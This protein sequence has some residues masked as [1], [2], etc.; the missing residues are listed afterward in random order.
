MRGQQSAVPPNNIGT[1][2][3]N[4][5]IYLDVKLVRGVKTTYL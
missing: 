2:S 3:D 1:L 5:L 4:V